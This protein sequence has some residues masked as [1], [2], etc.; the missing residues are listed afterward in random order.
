MTLSLCNRQVKRKNIKMPRDSS[1]IDLIQALTRSRTHL[2][3]LQY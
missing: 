2:T 3:S 1:K